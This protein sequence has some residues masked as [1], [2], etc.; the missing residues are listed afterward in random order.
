VN[1]IKF[2]FFDIYNRLEED[3][4]AQIFFKILNGLEYLQLLNIAHRDIKP[5]NILLDSRF[6]PKIIDFSLA[7]FQKN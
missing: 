1:K 2:T 4:A 5:E 6:N 3:E 7:A